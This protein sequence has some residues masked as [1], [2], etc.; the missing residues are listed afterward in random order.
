MCPIQR[1]DLHAS[2]PIPVEGRMI[3]PKDVIAISGLSTVLAHVLL[4]RAQQN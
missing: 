3:N 1:G 2:S 4:S